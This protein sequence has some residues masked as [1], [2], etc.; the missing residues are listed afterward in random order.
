[1]ANVDV[2]SLTL[3]ITSDITGANKGLNTLIK[4]LGELK[5]ATKDG[6]G[7]KQ[8]ASGIR[9]VNKESAKTPSNNKKTAKSFSQMAAKITSAAV[10]LKKIGKTIASW[11]KESTDYTESLNLF[12]VSMRQY[13][14]ESQKYAETVSE[15]MG[16][17]PETW[18]KNQGVFMTLATGFGVAS[19][20]ASTMSQQ[21]TQ[22]GYD[23]SSFFNISVE[24]AMQ[25]LQSGISGELEPLRRLGFDLSKAKLEAIALSLGI[26]KTFDSMTQ[27]EKAQLRYYAIMTQVTSAQGD[28]ARTLEA[29]A[30]Q[31]RILKAQATLAARALGNIFIPA[32][33]AV[34]PYA[35]AALKVFR[36]LA[37]SISA[38]FGFTLPEIDYSGL[39]DFSSD[40][41]DTTDGLDDAT[42]SAKK[43]KKMLLGIDELNV[44]SDSGDGSSNT[45]VSGGSF[46]FELPTYDFLGYALDARVD[47][48]QAQLEQTLGEITAMVSGLALAVGTILVLTGAS[49]P[50][51]LGL[52][53]AGAAG[54]GLSIGLNW[55]SMSG[56]LAN[57]LSLIT[58]VVGGFFLALGALFAFTGINI[59]LGIALMIAGLAGV[60]GS[61]AVNWHSSDNHLADALTSIDGLVSGACLALGALL[62][63]TGVGV[64]LGIALMATGALSLVSSQSVNWSSLVS[65]TENT[66]ARIALI[67][68]T[69]MLALGAILAFSGGGIPLGIAL[70]AAGA[71]S[72]ITVASLSWDNLSDSIKD[73]I[74]K[75]TSIV[76]VGLLAVGAI[77]AFSGVNIPLGIALMAGGALLL[78]STAAVR[79]DSVK[80]TIKSVVASIAAILGGSLMV[81]GVLLMLSGVGIGLGLAVLAAGIGLS[82]GAW[83]L[84]DNPVTNFV[85][86]MA[87][88]II[89][90]INRV[91]DAINEMFHIS[92]KGLKILGETIIPAFDVRLVSLSRIP[93]FADGGMVGSGQMFIARE[94]GPELVGSIG[95]RTAVANNDQIVES[96]SRGVYQAV[97]QAMSQ[98]GSDTTVEA[99]VNDKVLF[100][101]VVNR[102]RQ[103]TMRRGYNPL[104][105]GV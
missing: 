88:G 30:N 52:M 104:L 83:K 55:D 80:N 67:V 56:Q 62:A 45:S 27:A 15:I 1:M 14:D 44:M 9:D 4:T 11:I 79:W 82:Y 96:V 35:I 71:A 97:L 22:L 101:V 105:G 16:I 100:E 60:G 103:E 18:L 66:L 85:R 20:R 69:G 99:K 43:L 2:E 21:L 58:G 102:A 38:F 93:T 72:L 77:L 90:V 61:V 41:D 25:K 26:D 40:I 65:P 75:I 13:A 70:M 28:M 64:G 32:L 19:D 91:I 49:I 24:D 50:I 12:T 98:S 84:D 37:D 23:L 47:E 63:F 51:G 5:K 46:D 57:T 3:Q 92:F 74:T 10:A 95:N 68:G 31:L 81:L 42:S 36:R 76:S 29:P 17:D 87:N 7:L 59:P 89:G 8:V 86:K 54:L 53:A 39:G 73:T 94:A 6:C 34:L 33:N 78:G 48:I